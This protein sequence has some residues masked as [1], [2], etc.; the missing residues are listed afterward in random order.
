MLI[1]LLF[2]LLFLFW[3]AVLYFY[4]FIGTPDLSQINESIGGAI[5]S[6]FFPVVFVVV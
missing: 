4:F 6:T 5:F 2:L 1:V 3:C